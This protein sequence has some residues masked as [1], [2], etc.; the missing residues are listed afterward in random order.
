MPRMAVIDLATGEV[1]G[2]IMASPDDPPYKGTRLVQVHDKAHVDERF[3]WSERDGFQPKPEYLA[4]R[5]AVFADP[6]W[7]AKKPGLTM[8]WDSTQLTFVYKEIV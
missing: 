8:E 6:L 3:T 5:E 7:Q 4:E 2:V 1:R